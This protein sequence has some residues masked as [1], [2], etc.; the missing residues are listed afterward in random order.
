MSNN[1]IL[2]RNQKT[3]RPPTHRQPP[4]KRPRL[5]FA[6][7]YSSDSDDDSDTPESWE[8]RFLDEDKT[9]PEKLDFEREKVNPVLKCQ[10]MEKIQN[11]YSS[12]SNE[13]NRTA[14]PI[15]TN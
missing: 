2:T 11:N 15:M 5:N 4:E 10:T 9:N 1:E 12:I 13:Q 14:K 3:Q 6:D 8:D 7:Q